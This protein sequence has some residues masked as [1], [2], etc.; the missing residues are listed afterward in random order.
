MKPRKQ[1]GWIDWAAG[2][3]SADIFEVDYL[4]LVKLPKK[5]DLTPA[6]WTS[7][8]KPDRESDCAM[9]TPQIAYRRAFSPQTSRSHEFHF[10]T[11]QALL[12]YYVIMLMSDQ[13]LRLC[14]ELR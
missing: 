7:P 4:A 10:L 6:K 11:F 5:G 1:L 2:V 14:G 13:S 9:A 8:I 12:V 3:W